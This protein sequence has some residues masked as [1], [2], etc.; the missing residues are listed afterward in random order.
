MEHKGQQ[1]QQL[2]NEQSDT[3]FKFMHPCVCSIQY[4]VST[5]FPVN[6]HKFFY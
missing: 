3:L 5:K 1:K 4:K 2:K 6:A